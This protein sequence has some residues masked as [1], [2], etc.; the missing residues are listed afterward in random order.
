MQLMLG[1]CLKRMK[2]IESA[3]IDLILADLPYGTTNVSWDS[4]IPFEL[5]WKEFERVSKVGSTIILFGNG[6]FTAKC[7]LSNEK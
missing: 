4:V 7:I 2:E 1:D 6:I 3:S 5:L